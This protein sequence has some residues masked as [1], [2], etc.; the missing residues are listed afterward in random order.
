MA[1]LEYKHFYMVGW[2]KMLQL[3]WFA[4]G[5]EACSRYCGFRAQNELPI[6]LYQK[7]NKVRNTFELD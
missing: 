5:H 7:K 1:F 4:T 2:D 3:N 6:S